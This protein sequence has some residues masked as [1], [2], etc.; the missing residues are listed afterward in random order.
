MRSR[1]NHITSSP[2]SYVLNIRVYVQNIMPKSTHVCV[3]V[4]YKGIFLVN[5]KFKDYLATKIT[6]NTLADVCMCR[7]VVLPPLYHPASITKPYAKMLLN[8][9]RGFRT[10]SNIYKIQLVCLSI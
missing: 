9:V 2:Y 3:C 5:N 7:S 1:I 8:L 6:A 4:T 10:T